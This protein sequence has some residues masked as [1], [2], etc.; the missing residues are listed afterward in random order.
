MKLAILFVISL[1]VGLPSVVFLPMLTGN[2]IG[3]LVLCWLLWILIFLAAAVFVYLTGILCSV[4]AVRSD[5]ETAAKMWKTMKLAAVPI[6]VLNFL[7]FISFGVM[8]L[9]GT[10]ILGFVSGF[11]CCSSIVL[12]GIAGITAIRKKASDGEKGINKIHYGLQ[13]IPVLDVISTLILIRK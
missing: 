10:V 8:M 13:V 7:F 6:Y 5:S 11:I 1:Y 12:S 2:S 3:S 4:K 9:P